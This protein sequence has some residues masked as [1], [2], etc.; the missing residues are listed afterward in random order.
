MTLARK[1]KIQAVLNQEI[2]INFGKKPHNTA[3]IFLSNMYFLK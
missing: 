3:D 2:I 1:R